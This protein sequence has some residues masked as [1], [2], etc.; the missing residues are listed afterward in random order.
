MEIYSSL[1]INTLKEEWSNHFFDFFKIY[2]QQISLPMLGHNKNISMK[3]IYNLLESNLTKEAKYDLCYDIYKNPNLTYTDY[4]ILVERYNIV[5]SMYDLVNN[6]N[7]PLHFFYNNI[8]DKNP[9]D[10]LSFLYGNYNIDMEFINKSH[11]ITDLNLNWYKITNRCPKIKCEDILNNPHL[12]WDINNIY[13]KKGLTNDLVI[14]YS[15][16][17]NF[18]FSNRKGIIRNRGINMDKFIKYVIKEN[19]NNINCKKKCLE[20]RIVKRNLFKITKEYL[21]DNINDDWDWE[22]ISNQSC[23][24]LEV[25]EKYPDKPWNP[26]KVMSNKNIKQVDIIDILENKVNINIIKGKYVVEFKQKFNSCIDNYEIMQGITANPNNNISIVDK[27]NY[28]PWD[29]VTIS[30]IYEIDE[31]FLRKYKYKLNCDSLSNNPNITFNMIILNIDMNWNWIDLQSN[32][33]DKEREIFYEKEL[34][35]YFSYKKIKNSIED[36]LVNEKC[37]LGFIKINMDYDYYLSGF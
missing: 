34:K 32:K 14:K 31:V 11:N 33:F 20:D 24:D 35:K 16:I 6:N 37:K 7:L 21:I 17:I 25:F 12:P 28:L 5:F 19:E 1:N 29:W 30:Y 8:F 9:R 36:A 26:V 10:K 15:N 3:L 22:F 2:C 4:L 23:V 27:Y 18:P 13:Y